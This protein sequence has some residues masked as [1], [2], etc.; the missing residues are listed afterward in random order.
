K[1]LFQRVEPDDVEVVFIFDTPDDAAT[2]VALPS[3]CLER[4]GDVDVLVFAGILGDA[5]V[6]C[7]PWILRFLGEHMRTARSRLV[8]RDFPN[9]FG[10]AFASYT[11]FPA[12]G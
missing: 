7:R 6:E 3:I 1:V 11:C 12:R 8:L 2:L 5:N 4:N 10:S 9:A